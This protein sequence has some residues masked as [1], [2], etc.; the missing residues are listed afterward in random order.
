LFSNT[1]TITYTPMS[2]SAFIQGLLTPL[3]PGSVFRAIQ[4]GAPADTM[5]LSSVFSI[6]GLKNQQATLDGI[7]PADPDFDR[8]RRLVRKIQLSG[9]VRTYV[10]QD[11]NKGPATVLALRK[12]GIAPEILA[13][14][15]ELR[16]LLK[17]NQDAEEFSLVHGPVSSSDTEIAILTRSIVG[18]MQNMAADVQVPAEDLAKHYA[19]PGYESERG[20]PDTARMIRIHSGKQKSPDAFVAVQ[21]EGNWFWIEKGDLHSK[22]VFLQLMNLFT[23]A[24][25]ST[26]A[27]APVV[28]IPSR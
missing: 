5:M 9:E 27:A 23:M 14:I 25:T 12:A 18:I 7:T 2:G 13:D 4:N 20:V 16:R 28:T 21:Y 6:N 11:A 19:F 15:Q 1:P 3:P 8:V 24:D 26:P 22:Q 17:L 10:K